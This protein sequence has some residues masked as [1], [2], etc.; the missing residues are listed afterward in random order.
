M[1]K[2]LEFEKIQYL[3]LDEKIQIDYLLSNRCGKPLIK[4]EL[5]NAINQITKNIENLIE[6]CT[7]E[8]CYNFIMQKSVQG[9][10]N[11]VKYSN[12]NFFQIKRQGLELENNIDKT[13]TSNVDEI[14]MHYLKNKKLSTNE[15]KEKMLEN[16][17]FK[18]AYK[19]IYKIGLI[20]LIN[21]E[22]NSSIFMGG[23]LKE[24]GNLKN[25]KLYI[26]KLKSIL[27][28]PNTSKKDKKKIYKTNWLLHGI[29]QQKNLPISYDYGR[30]PQ[31][32]YYN[33]HKE[34]G[35]VLYNES[36]IKLYQEIK[37]SLITLDY[38]N[39]DTFFKNVYLTGNSIYCNIHKIPYNDLDLFFYNK[40]YCLDFFNDLNDIDPTYFEDIEKENGKIKYI[41]VDNGI[42]LIFKDNKNFVKKNIELKKHSIELII[43]KNAVTFSFRS[44]SVAYGKTIIQFIFK[45]IGH[46][47]K[48]TK[49]FD[50]E[51][52]KAYILFNKEIIKMNYLTMIAI[53][54]KMALLSKKYDK[55]QYNPLGSLIRYF[56]FI[57]QYGL[58]VRSYS[59]FKIANDLII[60]KDNPDKLTQ[61]INF[62]GKNEIIELFGK[63]DI[64]YDELIDKLY[65]IQYDEMSENYCKDINNIIEDNK[66]TIISYTF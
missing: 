59:I 45:N 22:L 26:L 60:Y 63:D 27:Y 10:F 18:K 36:G 52:C 34:N 28:N 39:I 8:T 16:E 48:V 37:Q 9:F 61:D 50:F 21:S 38:K 31:I 66:K 3:L 15:I 2:D 24:E 56:K 57:K 54:S 62:Y 43:T 51:H 44:H 23:A 4:E 25:I 7:P 35:K 40:E 30:I 47:E 17:F 11:F 32:D 12:I 19:D 20:F 46:P 53:E 41:D 58:K 65:K 13:F 49:T 33:I 29:Y 14:Y 6:S 1:K 55:I 64:K 5:Y 42:E